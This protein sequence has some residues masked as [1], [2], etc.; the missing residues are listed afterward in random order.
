MKIS[1]ILIQIELMY[2]A[3]QKCLHFKKRFLMEDYQI[4]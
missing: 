4:P 2:I 3:L 1:D